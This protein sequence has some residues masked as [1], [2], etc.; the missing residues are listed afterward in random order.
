M[1]VDM[2]ERQL[3]GWIK[4][5]MIALCSAALAAGPVAAAP[6]QTASVKASVIK[7]LVLTWVQDLALGDIVLQ[8]GTWSNAT[9][10]LSRNGAFS[11]TSP[12]TSCSGIVQVARY[13]VTG[14]NNQVV[15]ISAP[16]VTLV[17]QSDS[18]QLNCLAAP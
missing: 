15:R 6:S 10:S 4:R 13:R 14:S 7:P 12:N 1:S 11:C 8:P 17:N 16:P 18:S 2:W 9:V 5:T 3:A